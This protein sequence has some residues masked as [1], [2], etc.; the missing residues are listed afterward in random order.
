MVALVKALA[1]ADADYR[2]N[3]ATGRPT[4][5]GQGGGQVDQGRREGRAGGDGALRLPDAG[6]SRPVQQVAGR[7]AAARKAM[8]E[9]GRVPQGAGTHPGGQPGLLGVRAPTVR[10]EGDGQIGRAPALQSQ[11][12][13]P[14]TAP[15]H[16]FAPACC[17]NAHAYPRHPRPPVNYAVK[18]GTLQALAPVNLEMRDG[19]FVVA[20]GASGCGKTTLLNC[21]AGF[22]PPPTGE[23]LLDGAPVV[24]PGRRPR[25]RVPEARAD[26]VARCATTSSSACGCAAWTGASAGAWRWTSCALVGLEDFA[27]A[28]GLRA[29]GRHAAARRHRAGAGQRP[30]AAADGR[31]AGRA[32]C[33]HPRDDPGDPARRLAAHAR[34]CSS[35][36][37]RSRRRC[38]WPP[39][40]S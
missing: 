21:I 19:D 15:P 37:T 23:I 7:R 12:G 31:A 11:S 32:R 25:R 39:S 8:T 2:A 35:S 27:V 13:R 17:W 10:E 3:K 14:A 34:W 29:V 36:R 33:V 20:L 24:G 9:H 30:G 6:A 22:L 5:R 18:G 38:S 40:S 28:R 26:A 4:R 1:K 16:F